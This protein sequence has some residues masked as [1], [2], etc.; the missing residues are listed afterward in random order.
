MS[1]DKKPVGRPS[2]Y[3]PAYCA[4]ALDFVGMQ[5]KSIEE[6]A[7][8]LQ[9]HRDTVYEWEK[10]HPAFSDALTRAR[11]F[12]EAFWFNRLEQLM[13]DRNANAPL[14][15]LYLARRFGWSDKAKDDQVKP[16]EWAEAAIRAMR[17]MDGT[18]S[19]A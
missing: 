2:K 13:V 11:E 6:F 18:V 8:H 19:P 9:V 3:D 5:G 16:D 7:A 14:V 12:S 17:A 10:V 15:K 1:E 4:A